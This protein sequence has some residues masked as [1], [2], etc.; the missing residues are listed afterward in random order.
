MLPSAA[1]PDSGNVPIGVRTAAEHSPAP[2]DT[3]KIAEGHK[4]GNM[5]PLMANSSTGCVRARASSDANAETFTTR[6]G[7]PA[8]ENWYSVLLLVGLLLSARVLLAPATGGG[9]AAT[10]TDSGTCA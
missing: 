2:T 4:R 9:A 6:S 3:T 8:N 7:A 1:S 10:T 5:I